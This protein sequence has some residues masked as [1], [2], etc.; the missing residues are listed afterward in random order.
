MK[1][2][3]TVLFIAMLTLASTLHAG[4]RT[5]FLIVGVLPHATMTIKNNWDNEQLALTKE[6]KKKLLKVRKETISAVKSI[7]EKVFPIEKRVA[8]KA[9][10]GTHPRDLLQLVDKI[11][12]LKAKATRIHLRCIYNTR[13]ILTK[14]QRRVLKGL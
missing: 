6:Q 1:K 8:K 12:K 14:K 11:A 9:M 4:K 5:P 3:L 7:K 2:I 13:E 10:S